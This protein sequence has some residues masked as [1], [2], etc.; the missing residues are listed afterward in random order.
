[1]SILK[2]ARAPGIPTTRGQNRAELRRVRATL[3][4]WVYANQVALPFRLKKVQ[5]YLDSFKRA[6]P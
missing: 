6:T 1:M 3:P 2:W 5:A 4:P